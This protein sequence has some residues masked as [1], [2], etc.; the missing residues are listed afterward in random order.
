MLYRRS[1]LEELGGFDETHYNGPGSPGAEDMEIGY[2]ALE[3]GYRLNI[4]RM[5]AAVVLISF[6]GILIFAALTLLQHLLLRKWHESAVK[7]ER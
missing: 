3:A 2:R 5:F 1:V 7:R 6:T 4:P